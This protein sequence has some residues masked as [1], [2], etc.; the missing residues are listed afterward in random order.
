METPAFAKMC[1]KKF[2]T[3]NKKT[4]LSAG[5]SLLFPGGIERTFT[6][7]QKTK[8]LDQKIQIICANGFSGSSSEGVNLS[9]ILTVN[10]PDDCEIQTVDSGVRFNAEF[11]EIVSCLPQSTK[12]LLAGKSMGAYKILKEVDEATNLLL[13]FQAVSILTVDPHYPLQ[14]DKLMPINALKYSPLLY[15]SNLRQTEHY[16]TG[17][18]VRGADNHT[19]KDSLIN[20]FNI[21]RQPEVIQALMRCLGYLRLKQAQ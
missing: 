17:A 13:S 19:F 4:R 18:R 20:H 5:K 8:S 15:M 3:R 21:V 11:Y 12:L 2:T 16:P 1:G 9:D 7:Y 14:A 6:M 10:M